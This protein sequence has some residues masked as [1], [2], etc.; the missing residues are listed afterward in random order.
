MYS[1]FNYIPTQDFYDNVLKKYLS[2]G[3]AI[4]EKHGKKF[5]NCLADYISTDGVI[6]GTALKHNWFSISE[7]DVFIS[8]SHKDINRVKAFAGWLHEVFGLTAFI[9]SC[10]W[11]Y[12]DDLLREIDKKYCY[13]STTKTY[14]YNLR[15]YTTSHIHMMLST[16]LTEVIDKTECIL[17]FNTPN[18]TNIKT[19]L[20]K[21]EGNRKEETESPWI[22]HELFITSVLNPKQN[23]RRSLIENSR[24]T[25]TDG[26]LHIRYDVE[27]YLR[28]LTLLDELDLSDWVSA[29]RAMKNNGA[30]MHALDLL[31][32]I[33]S[34]KE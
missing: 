5:Q 32:R 10:C 9:D 31:Y 22:Y 1:R 8:H 17:F 24:N 7:N 15:N 30:Q 23:Q 14:N 34:K 16:A 13:N 28:E 11:N 20:N 4:Y 29:W 25:F 3:N 12:C 18:S 6:N 33:I 21:I 2:V 19:E 26:D 27:K